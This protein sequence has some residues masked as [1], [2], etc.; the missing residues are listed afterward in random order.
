M[1]KLVLI[2]ALALAG[3][4][5]TSAAPTASGRPERLVHISAD[6]AKA[7]ITAGMINKG[8]S[9]RSDSAAQIVFYRSGNTGTGGLLSANFGAKASFV[10]VPQGGSSRVMVELSG[11]GYPDSFREQPMALNNWNGGAEA[12]RDVNAVL[13]SL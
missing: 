13:A 2:L 5:T 1:T 8:F 7:K 11:I 3:C 4:A 10:I 9:L 12:L 6:G